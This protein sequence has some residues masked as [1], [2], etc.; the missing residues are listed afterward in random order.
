M[1]TAEVAPEVGRGQVGWWPRVLALVSLLA[2]LAGLHAAPPDTA[3]H[4]AVSLSPAPLP[5]LR[6]ATP[7]PPL[8][9]MPAAGVEHPPTLPRPGLHRREGRLVVEPAPAPRRSLALLG[10]R[11]EGGG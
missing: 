11:Q 1:N 8:T 5:E 7:T 2:V 3:R 6:A 10:R 4:P 9:P